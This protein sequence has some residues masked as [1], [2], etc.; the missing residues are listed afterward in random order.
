M[1]LEEDNPYYD[2]SSMINKYSGSTVFKRTSKSDPRK[3]NPIMVC[4]RKRPFN[5]D[6]IK[7]GEVDVISVPTNYEIVMHAEKND[8][9]QTK[10]VENQHFRFDYAFNEEY[11]TK[12][13]YKITAK[14]LV[15]NIFKGGMSTCIAYGEAESGKTHTM[16]GSTTPAVEKKLFRTPAVEKGLF[17][18]AAEDA[19]KLFK[20]RKYKRLGL[21][22]TASYFELYR[23]E[24]YD[25]LENGGKLK[26]REDRYNQ[27]KIEGLTEKLIKSKDDLLQVIEQGNSARTSDE[28]SENY[29]S[30]RS[31]AVFQIIL[32]KDRVR[33]IHGKFSLIDL[34]GNERGEDTDYQNY[35][36]KIEG[37]SINKSLLFLKECIRAMSKGSRL[38][39]FR[40]NRL[41]QI[42][43]DSFIGKNCKACLIAMLNP[44]L[45][46]YEYSLNTLRFANRVK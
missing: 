44:G 19:Y 41:T 10:Y 27:V 3:N 9:L 11:T 17:R 46:S 16:A 13:I 12:E 32:R 42:L 34:A 45:A 36:T 20:R 18:M 29:R 1:K 28:I 37:S 38:V 7:R 39:P 26:V 6:E 35:E 25:L 22:L 15:R 21:V 8:L 4:I 30:S 31:H 5:E 33:R 23:G 14:P 43:R 24:A 40:G 2:F